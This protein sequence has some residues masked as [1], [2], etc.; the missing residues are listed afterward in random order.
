MGVKHV[1][2]YERNWC[3]YVHVQVA[4]ARA[5]EKRTI[6]DVAPYKLRLEYRALY[7]LPPGLSRTYQATI[8]QELRACLR[9]ILVWIFLLV[10]TDAVT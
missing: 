2:S 9:R 10:S 4:R 1:I 5:P 7:D 6:T 3:A 8:P